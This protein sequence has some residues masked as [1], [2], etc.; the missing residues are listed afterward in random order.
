MQ[1]QYTDFKFRVVSGKNNISNQSVK[2][3]VQDTLGFIWFGTQSGLNRFDGY[4]FEVFYHN[5]DDST[6][7]ADNYI[8]TMLLDSKG[9]LWIGTNYGLSLYN[10]K[11]K[12][13]KNFIHDPDDPQT[14]S[15][16]YIT[17][18]VEDS[19][20]NLWVGT[21]WGLNYF[22]VKSGKFTRF[23]SA[24]S[25]E[26]INGYHTTISGSSIYA[27]AIDAH[28]N[29]WIG[30]HNNGL[31][32]YDSKTK[33]FRYY[34]HDEKQN[35][36][37]TNFI[38]SLCL[39]KRGNLWIGT[40][41]GGVNKYSIKKNRFTSYRNHQNDE[42]SVSGNFV[43]S[44]ILDKQERLWVATDN[45]GL[46]LYDYKADRFYNFYS[47]KYDK[48]RIASN[49]IW[50][51]FSDR[52]DNLWIGHYRSGVS[53]SSLDKFKKYNHY[54]KS[55]T[56]PNSISNDIITAITEDENGKVWIATDGGGLNLLDPV[57]NRF[58]HYLP[59]VNQNYSLPDVSVLSLLIDSNQRL[60]IGT[61]KGGLSYFNHQIHGFISYRHNEGDPESIAG[62]DIRSIIENE[63]GDIWVAT[64]GQG[65]SKFKISNKIFYN[66]KY[67]SHQSTSLAADW[68]WCVF[69]DSK[70]NIWIGTTDGLSLLKNNGQ[71]FEN[72]L[73]NENDSTSISHRNVFTFY[74]DSRNNFWIGT[75][76]G[77]N[78]MDRE[79]KSFKRFQINAGFSRDHI[80]SILEDDSGNLY[81]GTNKGILKFNT[82]SKELLPFKISTEI[83]GLE[84]IKN[85]AYK[86][87]D[88]KFYFGS[89]NGLVAFYPK[90]I[91]ND[92]KEVQTIL[93]DFIFFDTPINLSDS[94]QNILTQD[95][96]QTHSIT[97]DYN[98]TDIGFSFS[99]LYF[100]NIEQ[101]KYQY[102]LDGVDESWKS[103]RA[104]ENT[105]SYN[106]I[107]PGQHTFKIKACN[108]DG[109]WSNR[110]TTLNINV[111][112][113]FWSTWWFR[114]VA[115]GSIIFFSLLFYRIRTQSIRKT[116]EK[117]ATINEN[118]NT[119]IHVR[120]HTEEA[121]RKSEE[122]YRNIFLNIQDVYFELDAT[123][124][125]LELSP[126][127]EEF[128]KYH[129]DELIGKPIQLL[130]KNNKKIHLKKLIQAGRIQNYEV[131]LKAKNKSILHGSI[132]AHIIYDENHNLQK[133][134]GTLRNVSDRKKLQEQLLQT[135]KMESIGTLAGG[136]AHDFN[137]IL[138]A[139]NGFAEIALLKLDKK[140]AAYNDIVA[141]CK[142]GGRAEMLT[143]QILAFSRKQMFKTEVIDINNTLVNLDKMTRRLI[144]EDINIKMK[145][146]SEST[147][148]KAD[149]GQFEQI[150]VNLIV[151]ARDAVNTKTKRASEK[152]ITVETGRVYLD[153]SIN[154]IQFDQ[155]PGDYIFFSVSDNGIG[156]S[157]KN[158]KK[159]FEPFF[160][161]KEKE[162]GT[163]LGLATVYGMVKQNKGNISVYS[164]VGVGSTFKIYWPAANTTTSAKKLKD[165]QSMHLTGQ[166]SILLVEDDTEVRNFA[167]TVL[168]QHGYKVRVAEGGHQALEILKQNGRMFDLLITDMVMPGM[169]GKELADKV[170]DHLPG[171][172]ILYV[173]GYTDDHILH[174]GELDENINFLHKPF[175]VNS[176]ATKV[177]TVIDEN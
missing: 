108:S 165:E 157:Q 153:K 84:F 102:F 130:F 132:N 58:K 170:K 59:Q 64:H 36:I 49:K 1:A 7:I 2:S 30:T 23:L 106:N 46:A 86:N 34:Y 126:S 8:V 107:P 135:Q 95:I 28:N 145:L 148:I 120:K 17:A 112:P 31:N 142:A 116:N 66:Y 154:D 127:T 33:K 14:I 29:L 50:S 141:V 100:R 68:T 173:S 114:F 119:Q 83:D 117:L 47:S 3:I 72:F 25:L 60:W 69:K 67:D 55:P 15:G 71:S 149:P 37:S 12:N 78:L 6:S 163:G 152:K 168:Q 146:T 89:Q 90:N 140:N 35:S 22:D 43:T 9:Q 79:T 104:G 87:K 94:S 161:T 65:I 125:I 18:L 150:F 85:S 133:I 162:K 44:I 4:N 103:L 99:T 131:E 13:F 101:C 123:G 75:E 151:N 113:P 70:N 155:R 91:K 147:F 105:I 11:K 61:Y 144:G 32:F 122:K 160:T 20:G 27:L 93:T 63:S 39:D 137:N 129:K 175:T 158:Q 5:P 156:I 88:G 40:F 97:L 121:L 57:M 169:N 53:F 110:T 177:R 115:S 48:N 164:E 54:F 92:T 45:D 21:S 96:S 38:R 16:N 98:Q 10:S 74:E 56:D 176:L 128:L 159:I 77:L 166:E 118:L 52:D 138:T 42:T 76:S 124:R 174:S 136:I 73:P 26:D 19:N 139:I 62:N 172:K 134:V 111:N 82:D 171:T 51:L 80:S 143:R 24:D 81:L 109:V 167:S 41:S